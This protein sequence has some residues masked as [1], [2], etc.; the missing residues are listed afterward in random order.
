MKPI[1]P[2]TSKGFNTGKIAVE[3]AKE[4]NC[5][6]LRITQSSLAN[7]VD[8]DN[9]DLIFIGTGIHFGNPNEDLISYLN[10][11]L[12]DLSNLVWSRKG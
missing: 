3:I 12:R 4:L 2:Y 1:V 5:G 6:S 8:L 7:S 10:R 11:I 9:Y